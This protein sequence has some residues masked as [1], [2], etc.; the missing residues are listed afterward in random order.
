MKKKSPQKFTLSLSITFTPENIAQY[1]LEMKESIPK[2]LNTKR[3]MVT[4]IKKLKSYDVDGDKQM[5]TMLPR[6]VVT[7]V[8]YQQLLMALPTKQKKYPPIPAV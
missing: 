4:R 7:T 1:L 3:K 5:E 6:I 8:I 2:Q